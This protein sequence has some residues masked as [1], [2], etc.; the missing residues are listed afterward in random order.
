[1]QIRCL[2]RTFRIVILFLLSRVGMTNGIAMF[3]P[4]PFGTGIFFV[5]AFSP[6]M[7]LWAMST[8]SLPGRQGP[9]LVQIVIPTEPSG[10]GLAARGKSLSPL[11]L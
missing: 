5:R 4:V 1:M 8:P 10:A 11:P 3:H 2:G 6:Q 7:N 9:C